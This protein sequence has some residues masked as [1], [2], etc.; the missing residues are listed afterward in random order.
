MSNKFRY[1][2]EECPVCH[3]TFQEDDDIVVCPLCGTPHHR[4][5]YRKNGE[6]ANNEKHRD[7]YRWESTV[8]PPST[9]TTNEP[10]ESS[11][12]DFP[13][14]YKVN[15]SQNAPSTVFFG[16]GHNP[17]NLYPKNLD[18]N[19]TTEEAVEFLQASP[20]K[21][22]KKFFALK[23][24]KKTFNWAAFFFA[25]YWFFYRKLHKIGIIFLAVFFAVSVAFSFIPSVEKLS[26][27]L[28]EWEEKYAESM[29]TLT[30]EEAYEALLEQKE[31]YENNSTGLALLLVQSVITFAIRLFAG[32]KANKWYYDYTI[33]NIQKLKTEVNDKEYLSEE[34]FRRLQYFKYGGISTT[35]ALLAAMA[36][37]AAAMAINMIYLMINK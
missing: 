8:T 19:V 4:E 36:Y 21:Y 13:F 23:E 35:K 16:T 7:G 17:F 5:C 28:T 3:S 1:T 11:P 27:D 10:K 6:C 32:F 22:L 29:T 15:N 9:E 20:F 33:K 31:I 26:Y 14:G 24:G 2:N 34:D 30:E 25:P 37:S 12:L 18:E